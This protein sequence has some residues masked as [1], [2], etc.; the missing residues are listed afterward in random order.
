MIDKNEL[1]TLVHEIRVLRKE[2]QKQFA[3]TCKL[4]SFQRVS[5]I[6]TGRIK[7]GFNLF[8]KI[9]QHCNLK[10]YIVFQE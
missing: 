8:K 5:D 2:T 7:V 9:C 1:N 10:W 4:G 6:E 3:K